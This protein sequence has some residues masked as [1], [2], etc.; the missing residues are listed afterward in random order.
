MAEQAHFQDSVLVHARKEFA[1]LRDGMTVDEA[2]ARGMADLLDQRD[3]WPEA[4][5]RAR[6]SM[7]SYDTCADAYSRLFHQLAM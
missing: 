2:L 4:R 5:L 3:R 7:F 6:A 1:L